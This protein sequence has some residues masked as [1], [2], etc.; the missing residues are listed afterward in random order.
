[1]A[2]DGAAIDKAFRLYC[3]GIPHEDIEREMRKVYPAFARNTLYGDGGWIKRYNWEERRA[4]ADARKSDLSDAIENT[5]TLMVGSLTS[6]IKS[7]TEKIEAAGSMVKAEDL[8]QLSKLSTTLDKVR[9]RMERGGGTD[10]ATMFLE[11]VEELLLHLKEQDPDYAAEFEAE[12][13]DGFIERVK[14]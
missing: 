13:L 8:A 11:F 12:Y 14:S 2:Y 10:K 7:L 6:A 1:M 3:Q 9:A 4:K 5:E